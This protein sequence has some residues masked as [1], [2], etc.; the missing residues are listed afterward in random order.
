[1]SLF[2]VLHNAELH[3][4][5]NSPD[6]I[7]VIKSH[8]LRWAGHAA[9]MDEN[10]TAYKILIGKP[11]G[12]TPLGRPRRRWE[13]NIRMDFNEMGYESHKWRDLAQE[14]EQW[15][16]LVFAAMSFRVPNA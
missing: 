5:Y 4:L 15:R 3:Q 1:M 2:A 8:R 7:N 16:D 11:D 14:W 6:I 12:K 10:R 13:D 9:R